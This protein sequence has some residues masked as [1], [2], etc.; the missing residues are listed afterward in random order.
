MLVCGVGRAGSGDCGDH[1]QYHP[2][3]IERSI[4]PPPRR[5]S[6]LREELRALWQE[7]VVPSLCNAL[8]VSVA[9]VHELH[10]Y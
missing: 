2:I 7:H 3:D 9:S 8:K 6:V 1:D 4:P 5:D 10:K